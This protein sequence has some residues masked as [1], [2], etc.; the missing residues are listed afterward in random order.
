[1]HEICKYFVQHN[2]SRTLSLLIQIDKIT[3]VEN[4]TASRKTTPII[5]NC[6]FL[7]KIFYRNQKSSFK[8]IQNILE[9][10]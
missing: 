3:W 8:Q 10:N 5:V 9:E 4:P 7:Y 2:K 1:M 6:N